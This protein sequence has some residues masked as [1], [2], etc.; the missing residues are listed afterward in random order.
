[1]THEDMRAFV[2]ARVAEGKTRLQVTA[3]AEEAACNDGWAVTRTDVLAIVAEEMRAPDAEAMLAAEQPPA[4][5][6]GDGMALS[7][8]W[9]LVFDARVRDP[10]N[11]A[12][13]RSEAAAS[14]LAL[15]PDEIAEA[16]V[17]RIVDYVWSEF[18]PP[19]AQEEVAKIERGDWTP[20]AL[21]EPLFAPKYVNPVSHR[22]SKPA[23]HIGGLL[24]PGYTCV[25]GAPKCGKTWLTLVATMCLH[26]GKKFLGRE[27]RQCNV[28]WL[29]LDMAEFDFQ[30]YAD[31]LGR[32]M[33]IP[34]RPIPYFSHAL[35]DLNEAVQRDLLCESLTKLGTRVIV[36]DSI[37]AASGIDEN[38]SIEVAKFIRGFVLGR[39]RNQLGVSTIAI[40]HSPKYGTGPR[41]SGEWAAGA[42]SLW[43]VKRPPDGAPGIVTLTGE[44]RH[45]PFATNVEI[46][47]TPDIARVSEVSPAEAK[48]RSRR[49]K[50]DREG[51]YDIALDALTDAGEKGLTQNEMEKA[52]RKARGTVSHNE[53]SG[54][55][56]DLLRRPGIVNRPR[57]DDRAKTKRLIRVPVES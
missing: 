12:D 39:L 2:R 16:D 10:R 11:G 13:A 25:Y 38:E 31:K 32:G 35:V 15:R 4:S 29:E 23:P 21:P 48:T 44:G 42:D 55:V 5:G 22:A 36:V 14:F 30:D 34:A 27:V 7:A 46:H 24:F 1:M 56:D 20:P 47:I 52:I 26:T 40:A 33:D 53:M 6:N 18:D 8:F 3:H 17:P 43:E 57:V 54:I 41:G 28:A 37:R 45:A 50:A 49:I 51:I 19:G 9:A